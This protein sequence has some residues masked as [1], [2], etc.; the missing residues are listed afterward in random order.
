VESCRIKAASRVPGWGA[1]PI[2]RP[3]V[4]LQAPGHRLEGEHE[5]G[6]GGLSRMKGKRPKS[7]VS[8]VYP[9]EE[10]RRPKT[11]VGFRVIRRKDLGK[12]GKKRKVLEDVTGSFAGFKTV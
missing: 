2:N 10:R 6:G 7:A 8:Q 5:K 4:V 3:A 12:L 1:A 9:G 11:P